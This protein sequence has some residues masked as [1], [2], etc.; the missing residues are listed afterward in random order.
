M[1]EKEKKAQEL[2]MEYKAIEEHM[3]QLQKQLEIITNQL[4]EAHSTSSSLDD[5]GKTTAGKEIFVPVSSGIFAK[6]EMK[7]TSELLVNVG[8]GVVIEKDIGSTKKLIQRQIDEMKKVHKK[9]LDELEAITERASHIE[10][11]LQ[12]IVSE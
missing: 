11:Q 8:A 2:Y 7:D 5:L 9:M 4:V 10:A 12:K 1:E 3:K 6:A